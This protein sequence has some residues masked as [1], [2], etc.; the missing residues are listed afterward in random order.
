MAQLID[1]NNEF[2]LGNMFTL[3]VARKLRVAGY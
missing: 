1:L 2:D 3:K